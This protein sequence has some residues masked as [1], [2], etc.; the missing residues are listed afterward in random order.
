MAGAAVLVLPACEGGHH[1]TRGASHSRAPT[2]QRPPP[3]PTRAPL[4]RSL[5]I[6]MPAGAFIARAGGGPESECMAI[7]GWLTVVVGVSCSPWMVAGWLEGCAH[8]AIFTSAHSW[9]HPLLLNP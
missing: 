3:L 7:H 2:P 4:W 8:F 6:A 5:P 9:M 1:T